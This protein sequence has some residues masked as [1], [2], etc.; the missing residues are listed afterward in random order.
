MNEIKKFVNLKKIIINKEMIKNIVVLNQVFKKFIICKYE[1]TIIAVDQHAASERI[2]LVI[3]FLKQKDNFE[4]NVISSTFLPGNLI[5]EEKIDIKF[6][7]N[8]DDLELILH[9]KVDLN[10]WYW[11]FEIISP[12]NINKS[13]Y[14]IYYEEKKNRILHLKA[15][16]ILFNI[17]L[18]ELEMFQFIKHLKEFGKIKIPLFIQ[19]ILNNKACRGSIMFGDFLKRYECEELLNSLGN[20]ENPFY[21]K[22]KL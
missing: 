2:R 5:H 4:K 22:C 10:N 7:V 21:C 8:S 19:Q 9:Y 11:K 16:P 17:Q 20:C 14:Q 15:I 18:K 6:N 3:K 12:E 13:E 1:N